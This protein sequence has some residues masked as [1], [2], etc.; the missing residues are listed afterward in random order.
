MIYSFCF[1]SAFKAF[2]YKTVAEKYCVLVAD[3]HRPC[4]SDCKKLADMFDVVWL[5]DFVENPNNY[6]DKIQAHFSV[7][8]TLSEEMVASMPKLKV[9]S[10]FGVGV[11]HLDVRMFSRHGVKVGNTP[12]I[13]NDCVADQAMALLLATARRLAHGRYKPNTK[14]FVFIL[15]ITFIAAMN[16]EWTYTG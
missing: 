7:H 1:F 3:R 5:N 15:I 9:V 13:L 11:D 4:I 6:R 10:V 16:S 8:S 14:T 12:D 2:R